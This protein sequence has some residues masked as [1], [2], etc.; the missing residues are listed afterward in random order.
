MLSASYPGLNVEGG[1]PTLLVPRD[2]GQLVEHPY[3]RAHHVNGLYPSGFSFTMPVCALY[4]PQV[5]PGNGLYVAVEDPTGCRKDLSM[6]FFQSGQG[7]I[8]FHY[9]AENM[10]RPANAFEV[11]GSLVWQV[12]DGDWYDAAQLYR[13]FV[14]AHAQWL[15]ACGARG[16]EDSPAWMRE[17]PLYI[18]DW[19]P[20][21][22]PD[23]DPVPISIRP[24]QEPARDDWYQKPI[25]LAKALKMPFGYHLYNWHWI[26]FNNDFP[27]YFPVKEGLQA[28]VDAMH[29]YGIYVMPYVNGRLWDT[30]DARG[31]DAHF[32]REALAHT[33]KSRDGQ[34]D[35][36]I[37]AS[38]EPDGA[39]V[40]LAAMCPQSAL[41]RKTLADI[42]RELFETYQMDAIYIDQVA[43]A[44]VNLCCD[45]THDHLPGGGDWWVKAYRLLMERLRLE[46]PAHC[47]FTTECNA[48]V[49]ADGFDGFLTWVWIRSDMVPLFPTVYAG[50]IAMLGRNT[51]G[52]KKAD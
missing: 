2:A 1:D 27:H 32:T 24:A 17:V 41:W 52:Y 25:K 37:Y 30:H 29:Q 36:E 6:H 21:D 15:P 47:G 50:H 26:P 33:S 45:P 13:A 28:G 5:R 39:P 48:E 38:H 7:C 46:K 10:Y 16:R 23:A 4:Q 44:P 3:A 20:N 18:M 11:P 40:E 34:P 35:L 9:P 42:A 8:D 19:M 14:Q 49:Y 43:A 51:N 22:N 12:F 31:E